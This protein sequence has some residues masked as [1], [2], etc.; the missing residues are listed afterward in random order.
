MNWTP[1]AVICGCLFATSL[2]AEPGRIL[3]ATEL[4]QVAAGACATGALYCNDTPGTG[5]GRGIGFVGVLGP[6]IGF[7]ACFFN[8]GN[9]SSSSSSAS[10]GDAGG[11]AFPDF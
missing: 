11:Q 2:A 4:D 10:A 5:L 9:C 6:G 7:A 3:V 1:Y 8:G